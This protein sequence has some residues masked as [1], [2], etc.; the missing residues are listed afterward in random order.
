MNTGAHLLINWALLKGSLKGSLKSSRTKLMTLAILLGALLPDI[1][2]FVFY[3]VQRFVVGLPEA[4]I[5]EQAY[6]LPHW[7]NIFD[8]F[9]SIPLI[10]VLFLI[11]RYLGSVF[12]QVLSLSMLLHCGFDFL[13]HNDD[14]HR[15]FYPLSDWRF[16]SPVS[17][18]DPEHYGRL[19]T[20][21]ETV[22]V[23]AA[24]VW[25]WMGAQQLWEKYL[26]CFLMSF[27]VVYIGLS[28]YIWL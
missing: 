26:A 3:F 8:V 16:I 27:Q 5:W 21:V 18:W 6:F 14:A 20:V 15:H 25:I 22:M 9:N 23:L 12:F 4:Q 13:V 28:L 7:Q 1:L 19:F 17:Y 10:V 11:S 24:L 2:M